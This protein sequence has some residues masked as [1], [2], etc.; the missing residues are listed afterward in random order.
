MVLPS[1]ELLKKAP[2]P[3]VLPS[4]PIAKPA[5]KSAKPAVASAGG[6]ILVP[7]CD[8]FLRFPYKIFSRT[9]SFNVCT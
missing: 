8:H 9:F 6:V 7:Y 2:E 4:E 3:G 1:E 5:L